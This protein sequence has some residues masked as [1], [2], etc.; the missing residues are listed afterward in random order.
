[1]GADSTP[2]KQLLLVGAAGRVRSVE[3]RTDNDEN[4]AFRGFDDPND[5]YLV[6]MGCAMRTFSFLLK[7]VASGVEAIRYLN[8]EGEFC[9]SRRASASGSDLLDL[10]MP[11]MTAFR[12]AW[13]RKAIRNG[14]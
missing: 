10:K 7:T 2:G 1:V 5:R 14:A 4:A 6:E 13:I 3:S 8:A 9:R 12:C 11:E